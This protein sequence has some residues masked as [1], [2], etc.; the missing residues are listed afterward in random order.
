[1]GKKLENLVNSTVTEEDITVRSGSSVT[2]EELLKMARE[3]II[4]EIKKELIEELK[5][6]VIREATPEIEKAKKKVMV[7]EIKTLTM[8]GFIVA[9]FIGIAVNQFTESILLLKER[10]KIHT[11]V[12]ST[13]IGVIFISIVIGILFKKLFKEMDDTVKKES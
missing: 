2:K 12:T 9:F 11:L 1:M 4:S 10:Y 3:N 5:I 6:E 8:I 13:F 7:D